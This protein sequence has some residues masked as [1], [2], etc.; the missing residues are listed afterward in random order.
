[1]PVSAF[2][3][4]LGCQEN[5]DLAD[6]LVDV[7]GI[8]AYLSLRGVISERV[9]P[10]EMPRYACYLKDYKKYHA[11]QGG[12]VEYKAKVG[13]PLIAGEPLANILRVD[14]Y[15]EEDAI[16]PLSLPVDCVPVLHFASASVYQGTELYKVM[17]KVF[18]L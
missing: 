18:A 15:G 1:M 2:T 10:A 17:T 3:L 4:E 14:R 6:A 16:V 11:P 13:Q 9:E 7:E 12:L 8:M 5:V